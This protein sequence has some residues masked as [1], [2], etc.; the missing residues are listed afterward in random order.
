MPGAAKQTNKKNPAAVPNVGFCMLAACWTKGL[1]PRTINFG[2]SSPTWKQP[3]F[4]AGGREVMN[5][6]EGVEGHSW[7]PVR[8]R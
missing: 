2:P 7:V 4:I 6:E 5:P 8:Q 3:I 1:L